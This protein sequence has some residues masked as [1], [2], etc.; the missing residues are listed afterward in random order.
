MRARWTCARRPAKARRSAWSSRLQGKR[1]MPRGTILVV[2]DE[3]EIREGLEALLTSESFDVSVA[4][5]GQAGLQM[6]EDRPFDLVLLDVSLPDRNG[7]DMLREIRQRDPNL[8]IILITAYG[9]IDMARGG[10]QGRA[11][12]AHTQAVGQ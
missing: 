1:F 9:S 10:F 5:P 2:D 3:L 8:A 7:I 11:A 12:G 6:L 4:E